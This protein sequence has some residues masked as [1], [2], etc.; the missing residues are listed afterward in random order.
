ML[1]LWISII[2]IHCTHYNAM[3][4][5]DIIFNKNPCLTFSCHLL[6]CVWT[7]LFYP[8][9]R[10]WSYQVINNFWTFLL[11]IVSFWNVYVYFPR[12]NFVKHWTGI[13]LS[14]QLEKLINTYC[15]F[16]QTK[17]WKRLSN[18]NIIISFWEVN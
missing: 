17:L 4:V 13:I 9:L 18:V 8:E 7:V 5:H 16:E 2:N 14:Y 3:Q 12:E 11:L 1:K 15:I 10:V 6:F